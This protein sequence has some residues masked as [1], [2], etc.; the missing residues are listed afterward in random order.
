MSEGAEPAA[1]S[2]AASEAAQFEARLGSGMLA[3]PAT[4]I[5]L[6]ANIGI[7]VAF[8]ASGGGFDRSNS[9]MLI[10]WGSNF[11]PYTTDGQW[12]RL[13][14]AAFL[15]GGFIHLLVNMFTLFDVGRL[16]ERLYG[17]GRYVLIYALSGLAGSAA[18]VWWNP[19]VNS[20]GASGALFGV[21]GA[22]FAFMLDKRNGVPVGVMRAHAAS[23]GIFIVYGLV[24]G[25]ARTGIDN[26]AHLGGL[27]AG[28]GLGYALSAPVGAR[29]PWSGRAGAAL[30]A[31][32]IA[33]AGLA[34]LTPNTRAGYERERGFIA[35][36]GWFQ[37]EETRLIATT[38]DLFARARAG[39]ATDD[40]LRRELVP[41]VA[42]W[43]EASRRF[44]EPLPES[45][46]LYHVQRDLA[47]YTDVR[48]RA[49]EV[50]ARPT[51]DPAQGKAQLETFSSL[52]K[53]GD[54]IA[55]RMKDNSKKPAR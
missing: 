9:E 21:L 50:L 30:A 52:M 3:A 6:A 32:M 10:R 22:T 42:G 17:T 53:E 28:L 14:S 5:L 44:A 49:L 1:K 37:A 31:C 46:R 39:K 40:E 29:R 24:N 23:M 18:S 11:G 7:H 15:H 27:L 36:S 26:A 45:S 48:H 55:A 35:D 51:T 19:G 4:L 16:C 12:W 54:A 20:V 47:A 34:F 38:R 33:I 8:G 41:I 2:E 25:F 13:L 43:R